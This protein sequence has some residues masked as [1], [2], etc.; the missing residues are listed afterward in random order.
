MRTDEPE[1]RRAYK[2][3]QAL[4]RD[5]VVQHA[6]HLAVG[7]HGLCRPCALVKEIIENG[8]LVDLDEED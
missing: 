6:E 3:A 7:G 4:V 2:T 5:T 1:E 8:G